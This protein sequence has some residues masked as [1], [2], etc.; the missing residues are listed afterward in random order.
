MKKM[1]RIE[2]H[3]HGRALRFCAGVL[4]GLALST[5]VSVPNG[6]PSRADDVCAIF[7]ERPHWREGA[8][9]AAARW[10]VPVEL[11]M[12]II[13]RESGFRA[14]ARPPQTYALGFVPTGRASSA[15]GFS[16]AIDGTWEWYE[17]ETGASGDRTDF[18]DAADFIGW[19]VAKTE[20]STG[21]Q[22]F[23][24]FSQYLAYHEGHRGFRL[25]RWREKDWLQR[26]ARDVAAR[27]VRYRGQLARCP[28]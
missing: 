26:A 13:W 12:A 25:G 7:D 15:Y 9:A 14:D 3:I 5:C 11:V 6:P 27:T 18:A 23:D 1:P 17:R 16:Q 10:G 20:A 19:Y 4:A 28:A 21:A 24:A 8:E 22:R 2:Q